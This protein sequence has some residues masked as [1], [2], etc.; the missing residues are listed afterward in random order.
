M[1][2]SKQWHPGTTWDFVPYRLYPMPS[3]WE[4]IAYVDR[5]FW[6]RRLA[7]NTGK[8]VLTNVKKRVIGCNYARKPYAAL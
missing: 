1:S 4:V 8:P 2:K 5:S 6:I 7:S 3:E